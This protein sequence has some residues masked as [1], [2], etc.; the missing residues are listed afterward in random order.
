MDEKNRFE[1]ADV[2]DDRSRMADNM[3]PAYDPM[4]DPG[5]KVG[6]VVD[7]NTKDGVNPED[8]DPD[9]DPHAHDKRH[10]DGDDGADERPAASM[11]MTKAELLERVQELEAKLKKAELV[12][13]IQELEGDKDA[14]AAA[15]QPVYRPMDTNT[16]TATING[17]TKS[18][19]EATADQVPEAYR[20]VW[21][22]SKAAG[23]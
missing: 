11:S 1:S 22:Q 6:P 5:T 19:T 7:P 12:E 18:W 15:A 2:G 17:E 21:A 10:K 14:G 3:V 8:L 20:E 4:V 13:R 16:R 23:A 9:A